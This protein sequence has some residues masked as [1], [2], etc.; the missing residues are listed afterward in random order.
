MKLVSNGIYKENIPEYFHASLEEGNEIRNEQNTG[1]YLFNIVCNIQKEA[2]NSLFNKILRKVY[3]V[4]NSL[5]KKYFGQ[6]G[7][8]YQI[9]LC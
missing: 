4:Y 8:C 5:D 1:R 7:G 3:V 9:S 2:K 6:L